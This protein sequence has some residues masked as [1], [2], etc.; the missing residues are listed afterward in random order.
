MTFDKR[1]ET[2]EIYNHISVVQNES[3]ACIGL[4]TTIDFAKMFTIFRLG[5]VKGTN[6]L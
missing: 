1:E 2:V 6:K 5:R 4:L 3:G